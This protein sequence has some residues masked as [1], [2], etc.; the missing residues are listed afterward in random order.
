[1]KHST[2]ELRDWI[3][4]N[5]DSRSDKVLYRFEVT[6]EMNTIIDSLRRIE[7]AVSLMRD[8]HRYHQCNGG[9]NGN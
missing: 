8:K 9:S 2:E 4:D 7:Q 1:M 5:D 6:K 3:E